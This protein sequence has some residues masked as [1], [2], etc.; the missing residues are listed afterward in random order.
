MISSIFSL[1]FLSAAVLAVR[2]SFAFPVALESAGV[3]GGGACWRMRVREDAGEGRGGVGGN[4]IAGYLRR[5]SKVFD[6]FEWWFLSAEKKPRRMLVKKRGGFSFTDR[7]GHSISERILS[8]S[9]APNELRSAGYDC[10]NPCN[11]PVRRYLLRFR[12]NPHNTGCRS[13]F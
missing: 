9:C 2:Q 4:R 8:K 3:W 5:G 10:S 6:I 13:S 11:R 12:Y 1:I 7:S